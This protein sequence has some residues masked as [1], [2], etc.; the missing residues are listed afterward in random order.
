MAR[1]ERGGREDGSDEGDGG[2]SHRSVETVGIKR[3]KM[4]VIMR[5]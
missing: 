1:D 4:R 2:G 3:E 5:D